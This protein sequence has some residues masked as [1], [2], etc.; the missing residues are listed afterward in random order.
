M[1]FH[2]K[3]KTAAAVVLE[4]L[5]I[6]IMVL[7]LIVFK[8]KLDMMFVERG[9]M[10]IS[11]T[12]FFYKSVAEF[13]SIKLNWFST[14]V[15]LILRFWMFGIGHQRKETSLLKIEHEYIKKKIAL[16]LLTPRKPDVA[17][18]CCSP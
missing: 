15:L 9:P 2:I 1:S 4:E 11:H 14:S 5:L 7:S 18:A 3:G 8:K 12:N 6:F 10:L 17:L 16:T 13:K